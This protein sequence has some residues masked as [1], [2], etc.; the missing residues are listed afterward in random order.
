MLKRLNLYSLES[1]VIEKENPVL[2]TQITLNGKR[3]VL[4]VY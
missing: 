2:N 1:M 4:S 3:S